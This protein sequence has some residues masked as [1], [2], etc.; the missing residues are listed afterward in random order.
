M[1]VQIYAACCQDFH[2]HFRKSRALYFASQVIKP[3]ARPTANKSMIFS[4]TA[5][6]PCNLTEIPRL[7]SAA[8]SL[9]PRHSKGGREFYVASLCLDE[10]CDGE[11]GSLHCHCKS[12]VS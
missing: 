12:F 5:E 10:V 7:I 6:Q 9:S 3:T 11:F 8:L 2:E 4:R 1:I